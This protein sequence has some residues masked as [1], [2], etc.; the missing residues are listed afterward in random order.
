[1]ANIRQELENFFHTY[2]HTPLHT[3]PIFIYLFSV[4]LCLITGLLTW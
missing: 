3:G 2:L 4:Y 1:M